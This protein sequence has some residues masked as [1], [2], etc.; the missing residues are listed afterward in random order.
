MKDC[1]LVTTTYRVGNTVIGT[2]GV[3]GPT[4]MDYSKVLAAVNFMKSRIV[5]EVEKLL[6][7]ARTNLKCF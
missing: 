2:I 3:I 7:K 1:S 5:D 4:R 6:G